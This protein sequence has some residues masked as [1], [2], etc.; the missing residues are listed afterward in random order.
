MNA[1]LT[2]RGIRYQSSLNSTKVSQQAV[3]GIYRGKAIMIPTHEAMPRQLDK[4][5]LTYRGVSYGAGAG[6]VLRPAF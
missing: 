4:F 6:A 1:T 3:P 5:A 2:Y